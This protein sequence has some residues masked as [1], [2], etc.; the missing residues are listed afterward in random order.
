V[1]NAHATPHAAII[2]YAGVGFIL[3]TMGGFAKLAVLSS[4]SMLLIYLGVALSVIRFRKLLPVRDHS[5][6]RMPGGYLIPVAAIATVIWLLSS[7]THREQ[8][9]A[10]VFVAA[11]SVIYLV[12]KKVRG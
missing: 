11:L 9:G 7:L 5:A 6:F 12:I 10:V 8:I 3:A 1:H 2:V 4:A